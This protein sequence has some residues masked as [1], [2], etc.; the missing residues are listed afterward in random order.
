[1]RRE[2]NKIKLYLLKKNQPIVKT[3]STVK[4][5]STFQKWI[6]KLNYSLAA[7]IDGIRC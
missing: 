6:S 2:L 5:K 3:E 4:K 1:M 7:E